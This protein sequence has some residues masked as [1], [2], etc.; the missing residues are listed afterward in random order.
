MSAQIRRL[1]HDEM[2]AT[3]QVYR[4]IFD[5]TFPWLLG[6]HTPEE[7]RGHFEGEVYDNSNLYGVHEDQ[8]LMGFIGLKPGWV[9]K[10]Y[11]LP[12]HQG[13]GLGRQLL[14]F[15]KARDTELS[16]WTFERNRLARRFYEAS[17][18][19][20]IEEFFPDEE[21]RASGRLMVRY[22]LVKGV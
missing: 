18:F 22:V 5:E 13:R 10:L 11:I 9:E 7:D 3:S 12:Q 4:K 8:A 2:A 19:T 14:E 6:R 20:E 21:A 17:G 16:L 1:E 15:A